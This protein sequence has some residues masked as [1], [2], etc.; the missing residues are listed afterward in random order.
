VLIIEGV[1]AAA[2]AAPAAFRVWVEAPRSVRRRRAAA[3][4]DDL[5]AWDRWAE[6]E[7]RHFAADR[8]R[9]RADLVAGTVR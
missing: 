1:G 6:A 5:A 8:T 9:D 4:G 2:E 3:R 7:A